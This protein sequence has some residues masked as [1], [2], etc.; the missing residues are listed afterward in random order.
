MATAELDRAFKSIIFTLR[1]AGLWSINSHFSLGYRMYGLLIIMT[2]SVTVTLAQLIQLFVFTEKEKIADNMYM[3]LTEFAV[4]LKIINFT[5]RG[6]SMEKLFG[7]VRGFKYESAEEERHFKGRLGSV[8]RV[9]AML[10]IS[11]NI[12][13]FSTLIKTLLSDNILM[14]YPAWYPQQWMDGSV[15]YWIVFYH[16]FLGAFWTCNWH[17]AIEMYLNS[18]LL[19]I[20]VQ[21]EILGKRLCAIGYKATDLI[22][23]ADLKR[24]H[25]MEILK[26]C[27]QTHREI[28]RLSLL[29]HSI[30][31]L[32]R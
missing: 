18:M 2:F 14:C 25:R 5:I 12:A 16:N 17:W 31:D 20:A 29:Y 10:V 13:N 8:Y 32:F 4:M 21:M 24:K 28:L 3:A 23:N 9:T 11:S 27:V 6:K 7:L 19:I 26:S 1:S 30:W 22:P 15:S